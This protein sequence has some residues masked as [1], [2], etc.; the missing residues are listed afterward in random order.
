MRTIPSCL[1]FLSSNQRARRAGYHAAALKIL[2][3]IIVTSSDSEKAS[4][5]LPTRKEVREMLAEVVGDLGW[6]HWQEHEQLWNLLRF[7]E[8]YARF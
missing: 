7:P 8:H 6:K 2:A 1:V 3:E 5:S 4:P